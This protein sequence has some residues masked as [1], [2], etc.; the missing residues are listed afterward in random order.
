MKDFTI[1]NPS[2]FGKPIT[3]D[4]YKELFFSDAEGAPRAAAKRLTHTIEQS[5][6]QATVNAPDW[7]VAYVLDGHSSKLF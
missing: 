4:P 1:L 3:M 5:L 6:M 7:C 2:R